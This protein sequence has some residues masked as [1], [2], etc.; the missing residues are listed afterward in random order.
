MNASSTR[1]HRLA[2]H[3]YPPHGIQVRRLIFAICLAVSIPRVID[4]SGVFFVIPRLPVGIAFGIL[5]VLVGL[6]CWKWR[7][8]LFGR[9]VAATGF[10]MFVTLAVDSA[11]VS[12]T[13]AL[14]SSVT[15]L[16]LFGEVIVHDDE[17]T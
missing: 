15:A 10:V 3:L 9:I 14:I 7:L 6:T 5:S 17:C 11:S 2:L 13:S 8:K 16:A 4:P 12:L 1:W